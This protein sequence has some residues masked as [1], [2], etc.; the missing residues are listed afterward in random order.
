MLMNAGE[1]YEVMRESIE[2]DDQPHI[3]KLIGCFL[4]HVHEPTDTPG[5][6][7]AY[8]EMCARDHAAAIMLTKIVYWHRRNRNGGTKLVQRPDGWWLR[9]S[10][11]DWDRDCAMT[12]SQSRR[13]MMKLR[14]LGII[15]TAIW[16]Y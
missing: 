9:K 3:S 15:R 14:K 2:V 6:K 4:D 12:P 1:A 16:R 13:A 10:A 5:V 8:V 11:V 7:L